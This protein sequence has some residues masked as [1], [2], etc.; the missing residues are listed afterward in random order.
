MSDTPEEILEEEAQQ[1]VVEQPS[2]EELAADQE[3]QEE[4]RKYGWRPK[5]DFDR[6]PEG[7]VDAKRFLELPSTE[8]KKLRD[9]SRAEKAEFEA[10]LAKMDAVNKATMERALEVERENHQRELNNLTAQQRQAVEEADTEKYD[11]LELQKQKLKAPEPI[12]EPERKVD[13]FTAKYMA[14]NEWTKDPVLASVGFQAVQ[15][16]PIALRMPAKEQWEFA[17]RKV[18]EYFPHKFKEPETQKPARSKV[19]GGGL[20]GGQTSKGVASLPPEALAAGKEF[21]AEGYYKSLEEYATFY[22][23][24]G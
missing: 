19:D 7:W 12:A 2:P 21:V 18:R 10:R 14:E 15:N 20:G 17:E 5:E 11:A 24:Q 3:A 13:D 8:V 1:E 9:E 22:H 6:N 4:A 23:E 16:D